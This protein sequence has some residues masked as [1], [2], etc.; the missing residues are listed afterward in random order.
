MF[1]RIKTCLAVLGLIAVLSIP[2]YAD[3]SYTE[4][5]GYRY[6]TSEYD[7]Q[8]NLE[9]VEKLSGTIKDHNAIGGN[10]PMGYADKNGNIVIPA[11]SDWTRAAKFHNGRA[12]VY[13]KS[14]NT[15]LSIGTDGKILFKFQ[16]KTYLE[17]LQVLD[18]D[19]NGMYCTQVIGGGNSHNLPTGN[20]TLN[21]YDWQGKCI[22]KVLNYDYI[23]PFENGIAVLGKY[24]GSTKNVSGQLEWTTHKYTN[25]ATIDTKGVIHDVVNQIKVSTSE[26][27]SGNNRYETAVAISQ[28]GWNQSDNVILATG[29]SH[30]DA[31]VGA[32]FAYLKN[33][34]V[35]IT[36][37]NKLDDNISKE[38]ERLKAKTI[39]IIGNEQS[40]SKDIENG[41][42]TKYNVVRIGGEDA[43]G[44]S[45]KVS[46][47]VR[48]IKQ[49]DTVLIVNKD[50]YPDALSAAPFSA[51][52]TMPILLTDGDSLRSDVLKVL[53][54]G[55]V[56][57]VDVLGGY[58]VVSSGI[59]NPAQSQLAS[60]GPIGSRQIIIGG[61]R[62]Y[63]A[64]RYE[65]A[66]RIINNFTS[67]G[68]FTDIAIASG[69]NY[70]DAL[71]GAALAAKLNMPL[72]IM[73]EHGAIDSTKEYL[74]ENT[75]NKAYLFG[76]E[77]VLSSEVITTK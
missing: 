64:D 74:D 5:G 42:K 21:I 45:V 52:R 30:S 56:R 39:Y 60:I 77:A 15:T 14:A 71:T 7:Q 28:K 23:G 4:N 24:A 38:I 19:P 73:D 1:K 41:L 9:P 61:E 20:I 40:I 54:S 32:S 72:V 59:D 47:E 11:N 16:P 6:Y 35:L 49:F 67:K 27:L 13:S 3:N 70:P 8:S 46:E 76:G 29:E 44:T 43:I 33:A 51:S 55:E 53:Q 34:P 57:L 17:N 75:V 26:R 50:D 10:N 65:T 62:I 66:N 2:V 12:I 31:L 69:T 37:S 22:T 36:P 58:G 68:S 63:G 48:K 25:V 18:N